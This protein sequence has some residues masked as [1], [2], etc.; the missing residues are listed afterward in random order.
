MEVVK[1]FGSDS[2]PQ[3]LVQKGGDMAGVVTG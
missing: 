1:D 2:W 3:F